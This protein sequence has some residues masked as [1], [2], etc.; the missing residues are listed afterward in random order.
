[1]GKKREKKQGESEKDRKQ[2]RSTTNGR[3]RESAELLVKENTIIIWPLF[4]LFSSPNKHG[5]LVFLMVRLQN[6]EHTRLC[7]K[8]QLSCTRRRVVS[9]YYRLPLVFV[10]Q[11]G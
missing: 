7:L 10:S 3:D 2:T 5:G 9:F 8:E 4:F 6:E 11:L 1:M